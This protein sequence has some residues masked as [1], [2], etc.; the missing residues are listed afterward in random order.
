MKQEAQSS[1]G[2][3]ATQSLYR[4][5]SSVQK[6]CKPSLQVNNRA[7]RTDPDA[8]LTLSRAG[9]SSTM[10]SPPFSDAAASDLAGDQATISNLS[11]GG[12]L[13][14]SREPEQKPFALMSA[15]KEAKMA[16]CM[17]GGPSERSSGRRS[18]AEAGQ[19]VVGCRWLTPPPSP[20]SQVLAPYQ[21]TLPTPPI[22]HPCCYETTWLGILRK[23][24]H[25]Q[26]RTTN[27]SRSS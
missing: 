22:Q 14:S 8:E 21:A 12:L 2:P 10:Y 24:L 9:L 23:L 5:G 27:P 19:P 18:S 25:G 11:E 3:V 1:A 13:D 7:G 16:I 15:A 26:K 6:C 4:Y 20:P 17:Q